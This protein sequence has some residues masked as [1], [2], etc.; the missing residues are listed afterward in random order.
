MSLSLNACS[1]AVGPAQE[2]DEGLAKI[3]KEAD[4]MDAEQL[5]ESYKR[6]VEENWNLRKMMSKMSVS[7]ERAQSSIQTA[8]Q[9]VVL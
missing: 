7:L 3:L 1:G 2:T 9:Q 4:N 8:L 5:R 6:V